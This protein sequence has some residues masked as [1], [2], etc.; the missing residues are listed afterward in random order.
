MNEPDSNTTYSPYSPRLQALLNKMPQDVA[1]SYTKVQLL[2]LEHALSQKG[3]KLPVDIRGKLSVPFT[4]RRFF[5]VLLVGKEKRE[6]SRREYNV[7]RS[8]VILCLLI[9]IV[10]SSLF[11]LLVLYLIKSA[12]GIN[13]IEHFSLGIWGWFKAKF[14]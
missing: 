11:G 9:M 2:H 4:T 14:L 5:F 7:K 3:A 6:I 10:A 13:I 12:M 8:T 1:T